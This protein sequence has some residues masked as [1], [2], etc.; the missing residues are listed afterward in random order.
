LEIHCHRLVED[1][2]TK[3]AEAN[4]EWVRQVL[5]AANHAFEQAER[6]AGDSIRT[7]RALTL[8]RIEFERGLNDAF[9]SLELPKQKEGVMEK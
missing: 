2:P 4:A 8:A 6:C 1:L 5:R 9:A 7:Q 3:P